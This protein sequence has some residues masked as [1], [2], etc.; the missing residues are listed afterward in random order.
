M[1]HLG[2]LLSL[3][4]RAPPSLSSSGW[5]SLCLLMIKSVNCP[6]QLFRIGTHLHHSMTFLRMAELTFGIGNASICVSS[7]KSDIIWETIFDCLIT[8][9]STSTICQSIFLKLEPL[10]TNALL[11]LRGQRHFSRHFFSFFVLT[12]KRPN[13]LQKSSTEAVVSCI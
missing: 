10:L 3:P 11:V 7:P 1:S 8:S 6:G 5:S 12:L 4:V 9:T 13:E 2:R